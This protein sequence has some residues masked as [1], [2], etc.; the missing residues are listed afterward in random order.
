MSRKF[1]IP[2]ECKVGINCGEMVKIDLKQHE[3]IVVESIEKA[4]GELTSNARNIAK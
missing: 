1:N 3:D 2:V 4:Y